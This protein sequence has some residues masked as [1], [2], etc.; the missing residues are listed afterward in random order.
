MSE[1]AT[2]TAPGT[3]PV[4]APAAALG[5]AITWLSGKKSYIIGTAIV[6]VVLGQTFGLIDPAT[7]QKLLEALG[8]GG[9]LALRAAIAKNA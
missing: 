6:L 3:P 1:P 4:P 5:G 2:I 7:S 8:G 9:I